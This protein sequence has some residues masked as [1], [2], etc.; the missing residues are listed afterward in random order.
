MITCAAQRMRGQPTATS[1]TINAMTIHSM[2]IRQVRYCAAL[3][4]PHGRSGF[5]F[6]VPVSF[7][8]A[9]VVA[10]RFAS[11]SAALGGMY[12][13]SC[14]ASTVSAT[15]LP[16]PFSYPC[17][18]IPW[19]SRNRSGKT[20]LYNT[21]SPASKP[22]TVNSISS[23]PVFRMTLSSTTIPLEGAKKLSGPLYC[24]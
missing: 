19:L 13:S 9:A 12:F 4:D 17:A 5:G 8:A 16:S 10:A 7:S 18:M 6:S 2:P 15:N 23:S 11:E 20:P 24:Q 3:V 14:L 22:V 1:T 21:A